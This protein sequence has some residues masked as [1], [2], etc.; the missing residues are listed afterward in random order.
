MYVTER[1]RMP[2]MKISS[3]ISKLVKKNDLIK[4]QSVFFRSRAM[5][6][7]EVSQSFKNLELR[8]E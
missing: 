6:I 3:K 2:Y 8:E 7:L 4:K 1:K 5:N